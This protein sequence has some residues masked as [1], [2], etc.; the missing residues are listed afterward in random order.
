MISNEEIK[1]LKELQPLLKVYDTKIRG[2]F[3]LSTSFNLKSKRFQSSTSNKS[4]ST[5]F[6]NKFKIEMDINKYGY[7]IKTFSTDNKINGW[8]NNIQPKYW[9]VNPDNSL[10]L[11]IDEDIKKLFQKLPYAEFI[12]HLLICYFY[13]MSYINNKYKEPWTAYRH[14]KFHWLD[15]SELSNI[16]LLSI[17]YFAKSALQNIN[18]LMKIQNKD[19]CPFCNMQGID[20]INTKKSY[21][22]KEHKIRITNHNYIVSIINKN[23]INPKKLDAILYQQLKNII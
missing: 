3:I 11:G 13:Y 2:I 1:K 15:N 7:P 12:N 21:K 4:S 18:G 20:K 17:I 16:N 10:C 14:D 19:I 23:T 22:C 9:H 8:K 6:E 5:F